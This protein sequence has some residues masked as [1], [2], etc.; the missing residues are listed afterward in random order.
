VTA[1]SEHP[2]ET[3]WEDG[4]FVVSRGVWDGEPFPLLA[5]RP[6]SP[7]PS[8]ETLARLQRAHALREE[9]DPAW[10][11]RPLRL[12]SRQGRLTLVC[13]D[14]GGDPLSRLIGQPLEILSFLRL[15]VGIAAALAQVH[16]RG[17]IH[18]DIKPANVLVNSV[19]GRAWLMGFGIASRLPR[20][21]QA[22]APPEVIAGTLAYMAPE[23]TGRMNRSIDARSD[24]Y[25]LGVTF[26]EMLAGEA[27]FAASDP[28]EWVHCH[29][30][31]KPAPPHERVAGIP[32]P[33]SAIVMKLLAKN[34]EDRYQTAAG[35]AADL[36]KCLG[37]WERHHRIEPFLLGAD[38]VPDRLLIP[39]KLYGR[40][41]EIGTLLGAFDRVVANGASELV[42]VSGYAGIGKSSVVNE[43]HKALVPPR[44]LFASGKFDQYKRDIPYATLAQAFRSLVRPL[45][46]ESEAE[47]GRWRDSLSEALGPNGQLI[48]NL[49]PEL[50]LIIGAQPLVADLP[51]QDA[52]NRFQMVF[53]RF[54]GVFARQEHPLALFLDDLQWLDAATLDLIEHLVTH[55]EVRRLLLVGAYRDSEVGP[56]HQLM[57]TIEAIRNAGAKV[58]EIVLS[59]LPIE[60]I[61]RLVADAVHSAP[62]LARP[63][64]QLVHG[65]TSGNPFFAIQFL[66]AL[67]EDGLLAFDPVA[68]AWRWDIDRIRARSYT[69]NVADLLVEKMKRLS[70][71]TQEAMKQLACLGNVAEV[72]T[73]ALAYEETEEAAHTA[74]WEAVHA[75][76]V[77]RQKSTYSFL[78]DRIQQAAY[79]LIPEERRADTHLR[80]GRML[81]RTMNADQL[82]EHLFDVADQLN[83]GAARLFDLDEKARVAGID[84]LAG[85][86]AK[87]SAAYVS[88]R[89]YFS[90]GIA[91]LDEREWDSQYDL[92][93]SLRLERAECEFLTGNFETAEQLIADLV[94]PKSSKVDQAAAYHLKVLVHT[95][96]S[97]NA[98]AVASALTCLR[99]FGIDLPAHPT[100]EQVRAEYE[101]VWQTLD[102]RPIETLIDVPL[103]TDAELQAAMRVLSTLLTSAYVTDYHLFCFHLCRMVNISV[104]HGMCSASA[105]GCGWLGTILGSVFHRYGESYRFA[106][107]ACDLVDKH[108]FIASRAKTNFTMGIVALWTQPMTTAI[109]FMRAAFRAAIETGD[110]TYACYSIDHTVANLLVRNDPLDAVW[111]ESE[112][113]LGFAR[114]AKYGDVV[115]IIVSQQRFIATMQGRTA[116]FST[117][118]D[119]QFDEGAFEEQLTNDRTATMV[120][121]YW[122]LKLKARF[123]SGDYAEGLAAADNAK[124]LLFAV[125]AQIQL[126]DYF[127]YA[128]LT[129]TALY[130]NGPVDEQSRWRDLLTAHREQ[131]RE[132]AEN[133]PPTFADKHAL[134]SAEIARLEGRD[135]DAMRLYEEAIRSAHDH[136]FVQ[137]EGL[138]QEVAARFY[139]ARGFERFADVCRREARHCYLQ[140]GA[141]GKVKQLDERYPHLQDERPATSGPATIGAPVAQ[142]DVETVIKASQA[143]SGEIV[144][145]NLIQTLMAIAVEHAGAERGLLIL[146]RGDQL[147]VEAEAATGLNAVEVNLRQALVAPS[148]LP[149]SI[150]QYA[151][152][153]QQPVVSDDASRESPFS[154]DEYVASKHVRSVLCLPLIKQAKLVG[155]LYIENNAAASVF[156]PARIAVLKLLASQAAISLENAQLYAELTASEERWRKLF[157]SVP[158][159]VALLGSDRRYIAANPALQKMTGYTEAELRRLSPADITHEDDQAATEAVIAANAAGGPPPRRIEKRYRRKDGDVMW[160][161]VDSFRAPAAGSAPVLAAVAVDITERKLA[162]AALRDARADL[163]RMARLTTMGELTASIGHEI[164]QP[165]TA[166]VTQSEAALRFLDRDEPDLDEVQDALSAIRQDGMRAGEVIRGLRALARKSGPQLTRLDLDDVIRD[167]LA[168]ARGELLRHDVVLR[169]ELTAIGR[170][171][172][173]DRVQLQQVLLNLIMNGVEAMKEVT[174]RARELTVSSMLSEPSSVLVAVKDMGTGLDPAVAERMFQPFFTTKRDGLGMGLAICRSIIETHGG[175]LWA[176]PRELYG[177]D[178]RFT[179][180]LWVDN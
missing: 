137:N 55:R 103:M 71:P 106:K 76:L 136:G 178:I 68:P 86:R 20:E 163:E 156:T 99:L 180:P 111:R 145:E 28:M 141:Y 80:I 130:E 36:R 81:L 23:Q 95:V 35:L 52:K 45:L 13:E 149:L 169:T 6:S 114:E 142:L 151:I 77:L 132:W 31:R 100:W 66:T 63:L 143:V 85:R 120:C 54:L 115:D 154:A 121:F 138:A 37:Q 69:D 113:A 15:A 74:L 43:L 42:L 1:S 173:G 176:A 122:I 60:D 7:Q 133:Y 139:A 118:T 75:G 168:I 129:V 49:I 158:V 144:L 65:K 116:T 125:A 41:H 92:M 3:L 140:W 79:S 72:S 82:A 88:A 150:L 160:A 98:Q 14:P 148:E 110:L 162:E 38:D 124:L 48:V 33:L 40:E 153:T 29:I 112:M 8:P 56:A 135:A 46:S 108:G 161:E 170:P 4:E 16:Q 155:V 166:I 22:P 51:P 73:L 87:A 165:L 134:V 171:V 9:I 30:A 58:E 107:L 97:E 84:L 61:G 27:P 117:F 102:G 90:T 34:A 18:K 109:D 59:P 128:A 159:G 62:E 174:D 24:L 164:N 2:S 44:G 119:A 17:L 78:H 127:Y 10:A 157:E 131:L 177:A 83:R 105:H 19:T 64:A 26:Y 94:Q 147:Y 57:Q 91:L 25:A 53:R 5:V 89:A 50:E 172:L 96:K 104:Q 39:E 11:A 21:R 123:L 146:P 32:T 47:V 93:F 67:N 179:V 175:R 12:E 101:T 167:V 70:V 126:L 152:R